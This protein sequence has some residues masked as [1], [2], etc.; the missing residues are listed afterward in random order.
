MLLTKAGINRLYASPSLEFAKGKL[1]GTCAASPGS[2][3]PAPGSRLPAPGSRLPAPGSNYALEKTQRV[4]YPALNS[5]LSYEDKPQFCL[6]SLKV[7]QIY[8][9]RYVYNSASV[10]DDQTVSANDSLV[11]TFRSLVITNDSLVITY[12]SLV[13]TFRPLVITHK[14]ERYG[15][16]Q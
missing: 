12:R 9:F 2:R 11:I 5:P 7:C 3:L 4:K 16:E 13:I 10:L 6:S 14:G 15:N 1:Q 8:S